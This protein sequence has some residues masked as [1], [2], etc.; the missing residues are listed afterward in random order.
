MNVDHVCGTG[1]CMTGAACSYVLHGLLHGRRVY[2]CRHHIEQ[3]AAQT[4]LTLSEVE[5]LLSGFRWEPDAD[6]V[7]AAERAT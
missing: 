3:V 7:S 4:G 6:A 1:L 2:L 5:R